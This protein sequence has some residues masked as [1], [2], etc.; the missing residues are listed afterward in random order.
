MCLCTEDNDEEGILWVFSFKNIK[1]K[2]SPA[3][4]NTVSQGTDEAG[5]GEYFGIQ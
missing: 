1:T 2:T 4:E 5:R 3:F